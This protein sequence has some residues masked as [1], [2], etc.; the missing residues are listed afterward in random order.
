MIRVLRWLFVLAV[1]YAVACG[2]AV[3]TTPRPVK[4][5]CHG[6]TVQACLTAVRSRDI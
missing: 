6:T 5:D 3:A 1:G 4:I 2:L